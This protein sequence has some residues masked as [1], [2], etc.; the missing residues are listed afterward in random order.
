MKLIQVL[1]FTLLTI[2]TFADEFDI[3]AGAIIFNTNHYK[4]SDQ[5]V[6]HI[7]PFPYLSYKTQKVEA[8]TSSVRGKFIEI[9]DLSLSMSFT[10]GLSVESETNRT[11]SGMPDLDFTFEAGP[12]FV[13]K[14]AKFKNLDSSLSFEMPIRKVFS[15]DLTY[16]GT[17]GT[18]SI[19]YL[20][21]VTAP[22]TW[23]YKI[24]SELSLAA[25]W[26]S[27][28]YHNYFYG[29]SPEFATKNR[30][31]YDSKSGYGGL[32]FN[33]ILKKKYKNL[34]FIPFIRYD[35][36]K[37]AV[38]EDGPLHKSDHYILAGSGVFYLF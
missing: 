19:P 14:I 20:N 29:V 10:L 6:N 18:F 2:N 15:T 1:L 11:R 8:E 30:P 5:S 12:V 3:G 24:A 4:G 23:N 13:Y 17:R 7:Y 33:W 38:Y 21:F 37:S 28:S 35:Y 31:T 25:M 32:S 22:K 36:L 27:K 16:I 9:G 34:I 26:G